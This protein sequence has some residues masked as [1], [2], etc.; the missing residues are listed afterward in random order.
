M[1]KLS[2]V[3]YLTV[4]KES[5]KSLIM[6]NSPIF[7]TLITGCGFVCLALATLTVFLPVW[8]YFED[9]GS[10]FGS[11][12]GYFNPWRVCKELTYDREKCGIWNNFSR[13]KPSYF[14]LASG[15]MIVIS[16]VSLAI[17]CLLQ[18][19]A[20]TSKKN[21]AGSLV[22]PKLT[23]A[24]IAGK[25]RAHDRC[26]MTQHLIIFYFT[27]AFAFASAGMFAIQTDDF[28]R[29]F[30]VT[31]GVSF[32]LVIVSIFLDIILCILSLFEFKN[33]QEQEYEQGRIQMKSTR[34]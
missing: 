17:F 33:S 6:A 30:S 11:D 4:D 19:L 15:I 8:G 24:I 7:S 21:F 29:G 1:Y 18:V 32:Y 3:A 20:I 34:C 9:A 23:L 10:G 22:K 28:R 26:H 27:A 12:R 13:F 31:K 5:R 16:A 2:I 25:Q 14:V